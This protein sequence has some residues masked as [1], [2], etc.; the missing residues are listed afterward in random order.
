LSGQRGMNQNY[1]KYVIRTVGIVMAALFLLFAYRYLNLKMLL[2][3]FY[4]MA[5]QPEKL[6]LMFFIYGASFWL[7]ALAWK[8]YVQKNVSLAIYMDGLFLS[9]FINH[10]AP[11]KI[12][13]VA[14]ISVL[15]DQE[16]VS[17]DEA[18]HSVAVLRLFDML[19]LLFLSACGVYYYFEEFFIFNSFLLLLG[20]GT[21]GAVVLVAVWR[22]KPAFVRKHIGIAKQ[23]WA[24]PHAFRIFIVVFLSWICEAIVVFEVAKMVGFPLSVIQAVWVNSITV[25]GQVFQIAPGGVATYE[26]IM[27]LTL[28]RIEPAWEKAYVVAILSHAFKFCF[29]YAVGIIVL[30][31]NPR[32]VMSVRSL[33]KKKEVEER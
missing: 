15:A 22:W 21:A 29:S 3:Y 1:I 26:A 17:A 14:R 16:N 23:A 4:S 2:D 24:G 31:K 7:R 5:E 30:W 11:V 18:F 8:W 6:L 19:L 13:D 27:S 12:G 10:I 20:F 28:T 33:L 9:L 25:A 32:Y